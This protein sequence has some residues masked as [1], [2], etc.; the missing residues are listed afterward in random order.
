MNTLRPRLDGGASMESA[1]ETDP[2]ASRIQ[3][4]SR[5]RIMHALGAWDRG[6]DAVSERVGDAFTAGFRAFFQQLFHPSSK[7]KNPHPTS[8]T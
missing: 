2:A 4:S 5:E 7:N 1:S 8:R 3:S 6:I